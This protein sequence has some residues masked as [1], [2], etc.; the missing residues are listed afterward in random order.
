M[1]LTEDKGRKTEALFSVLGP[2]IL[3]LLAEISL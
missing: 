1:I 2:P 3:H